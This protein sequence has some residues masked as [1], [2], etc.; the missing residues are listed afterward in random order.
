MFDDYY[1][2]YE[3][4]EKLIAPSY[5]DLLEI[6]EEWNKLTIKYIKDL[7]G[8]DLTT[9][10]TLLNDEMCD[11]DNYFN[12]F[13]AD[14]EYYSDRMNLNRWCRLQLLLGNAVSEMYELKNKR[15]K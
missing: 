9:M 5:K 4:C 10:W 1:R 11:K 15:V 12:N 14:L 6:Q 8:E 7:K 13:V 2:L 3:K